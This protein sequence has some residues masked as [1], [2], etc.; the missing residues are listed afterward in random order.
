MKILLILLLCGIYIALMPLIHKKERS[1][2]LEHFEDNKSN[3]ELINRKASSLEHFEGGEGLEDFEIENYEAE[4][5]E[6]T[7]HYKKRNGEAAAKNLAF[8]KMKAKHGNRFTAA[9]SKNAA[10]FKPGGV[11]PQKSIIEAAA[12]F[13]IVI[14]RVSAN[15]A[16]ALPIPLFGSIH[17]DAKYQ[18]VMGGYLPNGITISS[19]AINSTGSLVFSLTDGT[20]TDTIRIDCVQVPYITFI[21][22]L[23]FSAMRLTKVK[24]AISNTAYLTQFSQIF[25]TYAKGIFGTHSGVPISVASTNDPRSQ[26][27]AVR[28]IDQNIDINNET[29]VIIGV[30]NQAS[31]SVT[32]SSF[33]QQFNRTNRG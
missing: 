23:N 28:E 29:S 17:L 1:E 27:L 21:N 11:G 26:N 7:E 9:M 3:L 19:V 33:V 4:F 10:T 13:D 16:M 25:E 18:S 5:Y 24:Y 30:V 2:A 12:S 31:F 8:A 14:T 20:S 32:I 15:L 22:A 6:W